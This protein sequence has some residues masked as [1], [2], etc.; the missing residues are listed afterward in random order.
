MKFESLDLKRCTLI[1]VEGVIDGSVAPE[2]GSQLRSITD[3]EHYRLVLSM[4]EVPIVKSA[5]LRE[6]IST[7]KTCRRWDRGDM[8]LAELNPN[9]RKV[10][11]LTGLSNQF[12]TFDTEAEAVNSF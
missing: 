9:V 4:K 12:L 8:R 1:R 5:A 11:D 2:L 3:A 7:W 10:L 6:M